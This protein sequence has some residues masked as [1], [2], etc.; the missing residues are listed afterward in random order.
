ME[1]FSLKVILRR[2]LDTNKSPILSIP[3][4][5]IHLLPPLIINNFL[6]YMLE[7]LNVS[8]KQVMKVEPG[9][10]HSVYSSDFSKDQKLTIRV[11]HSSIT[12]TG[13]LNLTKHLDEK[14]VLLNSDS[15]EAN[16]L[17]VNVKADRED[18]C[19]LFFYAPYW[20]MNKSGLPLQIKVKYSIIWQTK[21]HI[22]LYLRIVKMYIFHIVVSRC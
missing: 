19:N 14:S 21:S 13:N 10:K 1:I 11:K 2:N 18:S 7:V 12:W 17:T 3:N 20:I 22:L 16:H 5:V 15:T 9:E 4:Y 6:P 8:L